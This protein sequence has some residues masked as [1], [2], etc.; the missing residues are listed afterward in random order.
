[1]TMKFASR[2]LR[3]LTILA[4]LCVL[5]ETAAFA[6]DASPVS[7]VWETYRSPDGRFSVRFPGRPRIIP[8]SRAT[9][10]GTIHGSRHRVEFGDAQVSVSLMDLPAI[11]TF[12][13]PASSILDQARSGIV[14]EGDGRLDATHDLLHQGYP[15]RAFRYETSEPAVRFE[16]ALLVLVGSRLYIVIAS[17]PSPARTDGSFDDLFLSFE[18]WQD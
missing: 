18:V 11:A 17:R 10:M 5:H 3:P 16:E 14:E 2:A 13:L 4:V 9:I 6:G 1:M 7:A 8:L 15:A 12:I